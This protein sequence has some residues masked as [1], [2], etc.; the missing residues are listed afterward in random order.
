MASRP[1]SPR[2]EA[3]HILRVA[4]GVKPAIDILLAQF[5][6]LQTRAQLLLTLATLA[7]T[8]TGFSGPRIAS[9]GAFSRN[10]LAAGLVLVMASVLLILTIGLRVRWV[11]QFHGETDEDLLVAIIGYRDRK[12]RGFGWQIG[13]LGAGLSTYVAGVTGYFLL[14]A[15]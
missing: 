11:T 8:I 6:V 12:T 14:G 1:G 7:L 9:S 5:T 15:S 10:A 13:L 4:G 3:R 2:T